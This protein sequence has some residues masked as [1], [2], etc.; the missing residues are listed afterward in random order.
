[1]GLVPHLLI[2]CLHGEVCGWTRTSYLFCT[3]HSIHGCTL[4]PGRCSGWTW[5]GGRVDGG[6]CRGS[7]E[8]LETFLPCRPSQCAQRANC[9]QIDTGNSGRRRWRNDL[10]SHSSR[11]TMWRMPHSEQN[12]SNSCAPVRSENLNYAF[13]LSFSLI[14]PP[15][16]LSQCQ[17]HTS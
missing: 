5:L 12:S 14:P 2:I 9:G 3:L 4:G 10:I 17:S 15:P 11:N 7:S 8:S 16:H 6:T 13:L 1:M